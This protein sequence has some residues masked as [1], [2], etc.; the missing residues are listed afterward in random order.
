MNAKITDHVSYIY[1]YIYQI[2]YDNYYIAYVYF[3]FCS[4]VQDIQKHFVSLTAEKLQIQ[5]MKVERI[6]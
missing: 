1:I 4:L 2:I 6:L 3:Q 5:D